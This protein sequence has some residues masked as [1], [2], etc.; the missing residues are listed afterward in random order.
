M[1]PGAG[2]GVPLYC[3]HVVFK[4][5]EAAGCVPRFIDIDP[6]TFCM[7]AEDL[8]AKRSKLDAVITVHMFGNLCDN[9]G[10]KAAARGKPIIEDCAQSLGSKLYGR[11]A[12]SFG[13]IAFFSF[14]SGKYLSVGEGGALFSSREDV[15]S[16]VSEIVAAMPSPGRVEECAHVVKTYIKSIFRTKPLYGVMGYHLWNILN[17]KM[18]LS[19]K[20][21]VTLSRVYKADLSIVKKRL[22]LLDSVIERQRANADFYSSTL[23]L[24]PGMLCSEKPCTFYNRYQYPITF[25]S[26]EHRNFI[27]DYLLNRQIDTIKY[28]DEVVGVAA[29]HYGY[30]GDCPVA[31]R[32]SKRVLIIPSYYSL[33]KRVIQRI[34]ECLN[35]W[36]QEAKNCGTFYKES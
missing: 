3:C 33:K 25:P 4:A 30:A 17:K 12:G 35:A 29:K 36:W 19:E 2:I 31:E 11:L 27:A 7:S 23:K 28:L 22:P 34:A 16:R 21:G 1:P 8:F 5:I 13:D 20:S 15:R 14:R 10:L 26:S 32:L 18:N 6:T 9:S 24:D